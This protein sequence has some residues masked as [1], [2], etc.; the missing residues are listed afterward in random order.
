MLWALISYGASWLVIVAAYLGDMLPGRAAVVYPVMA[1]VITLVFLGL[2]RS[3]ANRL[4]R[5]PSM[6]MPQMVVSLV[7]W[8]Y[9]V[10]TGKPVP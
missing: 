8:G 10:Y 4:L 2:I 1:V 7:P 5:D 6:A 9:I 3:G